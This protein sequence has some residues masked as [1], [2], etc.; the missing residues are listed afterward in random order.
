MLKGWPTWSQFL[1]AVLIGFIFFCALFL[2]ARLPS[3]TPITLL[4]TPSPAPLHVDVVGSVVNPGVYLLPHGARI[5]DAINSAGGLTDLADRE[6]VNF[7]AVLK[8][9]QQVYIPQTGTHSSPQPQR[10][11]R[12]ALLDLNT[13]TYEQLVAL[14]GVGEIKAHAILSYRNEAGGFHSVDE[15]R[16][17]AGIGDALFSQLE[18]LV[19]VVP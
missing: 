8:D 11:D 1:L 6:Q 10:D 5:Q 4:P 3:G 18:P 16:D 14:P 19:V 2:A 17:V 15:L 12:I 7:A 13:A 9:G